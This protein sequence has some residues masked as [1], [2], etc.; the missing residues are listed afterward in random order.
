MPN[1]VPTNRRNNRHELF[2][3]ELF[4]QIALDALDAAGTHVINTVDDTHAARQNPV[5]LNSA[6]T[7]RR[8]VTHDALRNAQGRLLDKRQRFFARKSNTVM[9]FRLEIP[10]LELSVNAVSR[11][12]HYNN[13]DTGLV[14]KGDVAHQHGEHRMVHEAIVNLQDEKLPLE[15]VHVAKHFPDEPGN[16]EVLRIKIGRCITHGLKSSNRKNEGQTVLRI[17]IKNSAFFLRHSTRSRH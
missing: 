14:Q 3:H 11:S 1:L 8:E 17:L 12:R 7:A 2:V 5:P 10:G 13:T 4:Q 9:E 6:E 15:P 16:F